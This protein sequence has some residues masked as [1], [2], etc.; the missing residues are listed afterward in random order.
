VSAASSIQQMFQR[1]DAA[2][3]PFLAGDATLILALWSHANDVTVFGGSGAYAQGWHAVQPRLEWA[4]RHFRAG[5]ERRNAWQWMRAGISPTQSTLNA[6]TR[7]RRGV[8]NGT[9]SPYT[10]RNSTAVKRVKG[11]SPITM[12]TP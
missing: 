5:P 6:V 3:V 12:P 1:V 11:R 8:R 2:S 9:H 7:R 4:A 10:S